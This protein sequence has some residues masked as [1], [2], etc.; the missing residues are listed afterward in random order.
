MIIRPPFSS[1][2][3]KMVQLLK[4]SLG[5]SIIKK[6]LGV[7]NYKHLE[8]PFGPSKVLVAE[9]KEKLIGLRAFMS[10]KWQ[11]GDKVWQAWRAVDTATHPQYQ[12]KGIFKTLTQ[13]AIKEVAEQEQSFIFN[14][15]NEKSRPGY[16]K[17]GWKALGRLNI[18]LI[19]SLLYVFHAFRAKNK[20]RKILSDN[21]LQYICEKHNRNRKESGK[22]FTPKSTEYLNWRY[23]D[24][25]MQTYIILTGEGWYVAAY[26]RKHKYFRE[27]RVAEAIGSYNPK[28]KKNIKRQVAKLALKRRCLLIST[29]Q[30]KLFTLRYFGA[31]G[32]ILTANDLTPNNEIIQYEKGIEPWYYEMGDLEL[33]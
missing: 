5:E 13:Q 3:F 26:V 10:W 17:M 27:L 29:T 15:P 20:Q 33:F 22:L 18:A 30:Q 11:Q 23:R 24:N 31:V 7:W 19:P 21:Q 16:L 2:G 4:W 9:E 25:P 32:P 14:T 8:N 6:T 1:E 12:G 28:H